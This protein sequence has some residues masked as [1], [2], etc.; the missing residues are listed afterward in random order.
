MKTIIR[1]G[2]TFRRVLKFTNHKTGKIIDLSNCEAYCQMRDKPG[3]FLISTAQC[4]IDTNLG[5]VSAFF[6][7]EQTKKFPIGNAGYDILL[8]SDQDKRIVYSE[9]VCIEQSYTENIGE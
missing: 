6:T 8:V 2:E 4:D 9:T 7:S 1:Q 5:T 3:G